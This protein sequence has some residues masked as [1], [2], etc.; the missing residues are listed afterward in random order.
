MIYAI[1]SGVSEDKSKKLFDIIQKTF[2]EDHTRMT[3]SEYKTA[4]IYVYGDWTSKFPTSVE[5][6]TSKGKLLSAKESFGNTD[7]LDV[8][9]NYTANEIFSK[10]DKE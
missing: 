6:I 8:F 1:M 5:F 7:Y 2:G 4:T 3:Y 10:L 9:K